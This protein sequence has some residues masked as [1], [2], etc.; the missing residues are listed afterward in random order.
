MIRRKQVLVL[1]PHT[2]DAELGCGGTI[3]RFVDEGVQIHVAAFSTAEESRPAGTPEGI[4]KDEFL[5]AMPRLGVLP[6]NLV[7]YDFPVRKLSYYRQEVLE[8]LVSIRNSLQPDMV[9]VPSGADLHQDHQVLYNEAIRAFKQVTLWGYELPWNHITF[10]AQAFIILEERH[11]KRKWEALSAYD[12]QFAMN[13][14]YFREDFI[15]SLAR[16]RGAQI[17]V[18]FAEAFEVVRTRI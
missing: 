13:R 12:S 16:V 7:I 2:D 1:A 15:C 4:L 11:I 17:G 18:P 3:A 6:E 8:K 14:L 10:A 5:R 9:L